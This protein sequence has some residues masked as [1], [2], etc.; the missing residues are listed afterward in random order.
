MQ[1]HFYSI[2]F[3]V[4]GLPNIDVF[5]VTPSPEEISMK[6]SSKQCV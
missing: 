5:R 4:W 6:K 2:I 1:P 3:D